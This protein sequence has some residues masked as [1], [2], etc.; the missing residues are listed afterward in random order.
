MGEELL[1][2]LDPKSQGI[3]RIM[4]YPDGK[5]LLILTASGIST[6]EGV[7]LYVVDL[8]KKSAEDLIVIQGN[9]SDTVWQEP[10]KSILVSRTMNGLTNIWKL[11]LADKSLTQVTFGP[12][13][14]HSP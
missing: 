6:V 9:P 3:T 14:D 11:N 2:T 13:P 5:H 10:G 8:E 1:V 12:G 4:P 7:Q